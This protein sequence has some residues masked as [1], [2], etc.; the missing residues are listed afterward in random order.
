MSLNSSTVPNVISNASTHTN[1]N[2][3]TNTNVNGNGN[4][5]AP[6]LN[7][8]DQPIEVINANRDK[9][10]NLINILDNNQNGN[11]TPKRV[12]EVKPL[13]NFTFKFD[14]KRFESKTAPKETKIEDRKEIPHHQR[15]IANP[16]LTPTSP[17]NLIAE[18]EMSELEDESNDDDNSMDQSPV[19]TENEENEENEFESLNSSADFDDIVNIVEPISLMKFAIIFDRLEAPTGRVQS[20]A[21]IHYDSLTFQS[22]DLSPYTAISLYQANFPSIYPNTT[23]SYLLILPVCFSFLGFFSNYCY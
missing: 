18:E 9:N 14:T 6:G 23:N 17:N 13:N 7:K 22:S 4:G 10:K 8:V 20:K 21:L 15:T 19:E 1:T 3:N 16:L 2:I 12:G 5:K 11:E